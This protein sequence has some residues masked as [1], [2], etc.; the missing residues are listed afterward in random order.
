M[1]ASAYVKQRDRL[2]I[3]TFATS[4]PRY[5]ICGAITRS[6]R[7]AR[8]DDDPI[9]DSYHYCLEGEGRD[10]LLQ[11]SSVPYWSQK[12]NIKASKRRGYMTTPLYPPWERRTSLV[13]ETTY[14][15]KLPRTRTMQHRE[16]SP[17]CLSTSTQTGVRA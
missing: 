1:T 13:L 4:P 3:L 11:G 16:G 5:L 12:S 10:S 6:K 15:H 9:D 2:D 14:Q 8:T 7:T 17:V